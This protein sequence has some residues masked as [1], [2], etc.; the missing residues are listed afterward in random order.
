MITRS[1]RGSLFLA[2]GLIVIAL[3]MTAV[4]SRGWLGA[5][6]CACWVLKRVGRGKRECYENETLC[7]EEIA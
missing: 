2:G 6:N 3:A 4:E 5:D 1:V 7:H